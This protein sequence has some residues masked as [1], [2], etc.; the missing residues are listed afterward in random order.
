MNIKFMVLQENKV[1]ILFVTFI[2]TSVDCLLIVFLK[3]PFLHKGETAHKRWTDQSHSGMMKSMGMS[4]SQ[5]VEA[6]RNQGSL[7]SLVWDVTR[8]RI[9]PDSPR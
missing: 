9:R 2:Q 7:K 1:I 4:L 5:A 8:G 6:S 3:F